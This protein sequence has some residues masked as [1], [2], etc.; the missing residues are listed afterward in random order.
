MKKIITIFIIISVKALLFAGPAAG[1]YTERLSEN[2]KSFDDLGILIGVVFG[3][4]IGVM[5][6]I[7][8]I[9]NKFKS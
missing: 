3:L 8:Y 7:D 5:M 4:F 6:L 1:M 2:P 9:K